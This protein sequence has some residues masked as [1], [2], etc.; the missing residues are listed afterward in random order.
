MT[1]C[2][3]CGE[4]NPDKAKI[5]PGVRHAPEAMRVHLADEGPITSGGGRL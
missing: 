5:L 1:V 3:N 4:D 2:P